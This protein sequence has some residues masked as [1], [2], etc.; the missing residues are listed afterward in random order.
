M[1]DARYVY[2]Y[3]VERLNRTKENTTFYTL[4]KDI[5]TILTKK[6]PYTKRTPFDIKANAI[7][8][9]HTAVLNAKKSCK[10]NRIYCNVTYKTKKDD[11]QSVYIPKANVRKN[12]FYTKT[13]KGSLHPS[14]PFDKPPKDCTLHYKRNV[15]FYFIMPEDI[16]L[17]NQEKFDD[18]IALDPGVRTFMTGYSQSG[19]VEFGNKD[20]GKITRLQKHLRKLKTSVHS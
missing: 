9:A 15:G 2:N 16:I 17:E 11:S 3:T 10:K 14:V 1:G 6:Y 13:M 20:I 12:T 18:F 19:I 8:D 7:K 5:M 4:R